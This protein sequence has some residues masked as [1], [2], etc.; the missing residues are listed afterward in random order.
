MDI[1]DEI[2]K[3]KNTVAI[4]ERRLEKMEYKVCIFSD[5]ES[6]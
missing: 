4:H 3:L 6:I 2:R 5:Y 1:E